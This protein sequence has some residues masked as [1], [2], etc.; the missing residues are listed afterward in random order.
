MK[1]SLY[2]INGALISLLEE[3]E[4]NGGELT[5]EI[6]SQLEIKEAELFEKTSGY[7]EII[8]SQEAFIS[9]IDEEIK[10]LEARKKQSKNL[11]DRLKSNLVNAVEVFGEIELETATV[12]TRKSV[13]VE[14]TDVNSLPDIYKL[15]KVTEAANKTVIKKDLKEGVVIDGCQLIENKNLKIK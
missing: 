14:V 6:A 13:S 9:R 1:N 3:I 2:Q 10:R 5:E 15:K 4:E 8:G 11:V 12:T 7:L